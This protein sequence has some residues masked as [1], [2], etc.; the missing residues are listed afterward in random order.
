LT[1]PARVVV[2]SVQ[3]TRQRDATRHRENETAMPRDKNPK[4]PHDAKHRYE[5]KIRHFDDRAGR[6]G[7]NLLVI[8]DACLVDSEDITLI[9]C[10]DGI[11]SNNDALTAECQ[12]RIDLAESPLRIELAEHADYAEAHACVQ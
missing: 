9:K 11:E 3:A 10:T 12:R 1:P 5:W 7:C 8:Y 2:L 4:I 6:L